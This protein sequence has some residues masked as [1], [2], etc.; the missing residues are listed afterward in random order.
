MS[1]TLLC[2]KGHLDPPGLCWRIGERLFSP[3]MEDD[4]PDFFSRKL[5]SLVPRL[6]LSIQALHWDDT[7]QNPLHQTWNAPQVKIGESWT[8]P[9]NLHR[10][11]EL[12]DGKMYRKTI[13][14]DGNN[15]GFL[16]IF[17]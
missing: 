3:K 2:K 6:V 1:L 11:I 5:S 7:G 9:G 16:Q 4:A 12:D 13:F 8:W 10:F 17:P 15:H 14:F